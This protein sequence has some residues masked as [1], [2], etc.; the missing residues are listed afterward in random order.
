[1]SPS[2]FWSVLRVEPFAEGTRFEKERLWHVKIAFGI[3]LKGPLLI[4]NGRFAG[5]GLM[6]PVPGAVAGVHAFTVVEGLI[7]EPQPLIL[8]RALRRAVMARIQALIGE[9]KLSSFFTGHEADG[10]PLR[11]VNSSH[12]AFA[13]EPVSR[14]L[15]VLAPHLLERRSQTKEEYK[16]LSKL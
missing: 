7:G 13:Y 15:I 8:A 6:A 2:T 12:L 10:A 9:R 4:G 5:L 14:Q 11:R 3:P 1:V 16:Y